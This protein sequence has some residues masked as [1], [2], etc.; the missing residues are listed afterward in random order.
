MRVDCGRMAGTLAKPLYNY[1]V[2]EITPWGLC[3][4]LVEFFCGRFRDGQT[5]HKPPI[6]LT[7]IGRTPI[8]PTKPPIAITPIGLT[9]IGLTPIRP[10]YLD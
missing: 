2:P 1:F 10:T 9:P 8:G 5:D 4:N 3:G 7:P 6:R